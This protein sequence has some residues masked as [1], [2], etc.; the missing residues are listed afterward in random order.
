MNI[1]TRVRKVFLLA[2]LTVLFCSFSQI[3]SYADVLPT[4]R[5]TPSNGNVF[6]AFPGYYYPDSK[7]KILKEINR[8]RY[9][10]CKEGLRNPNDPSKRL[11]LS[12][13]KPIKWSYDM[14][15]IARIRAAE[16]ALGGYDLGHTRPNY[17]I[18]FS[19]ESKAG[20]SSRS[21]SLA[22][23]YSGIMVGIQQWYE[24]KQD[25]IRDSADGKID[26][27][28]AVGHYMHLINPGFTHTAVAAFWYSNNAWVGVAQE[29]YRSDT[30][31]NESKINLTGYRT[32]RIEVNKDFLKLRP[33][34]WFK[35]MNHWYC[36]DSSRNFVTGK[37][38]VN[39]KSYFFDK[40]GMMK[41]GWVKDGGNWYYINSNGSKR[42]GWIKSSGNWYFLNS[43]GS[44][45][46]GWV[47]AS[48]KW[49][50]MDKKNGAM[51]TY[52][53]KDGDNWYYLGGDG[54]M[55]TGWTKSGS[56]WYFLNSDGSMRTA[57]LTEGNT[58][59][60]FNTSGAMI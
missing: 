1:S 26:N 21:E 7:G 46:T 35:F 60:K 24:E 16:S 47:K 49:Y 13:Y 57:D 25:Y 43:D 58:I 31:L 17:E 33:N 22:W 6:I 36:T 23:N 10:A 59:Y 5:E 32:Q 12:D 52:W 14:E 45:K 38:N 40:Y 4:D 28:A 48:S 51:K 54:V 34:S 39:G 30:S 3:Q 56:N 44:M 8:I 53:V 20:L 19:L 37:I 50:Y 11:S 9:E 27:V 15:Q 29:S 42:T 18:C 2:F 55:R 41:T